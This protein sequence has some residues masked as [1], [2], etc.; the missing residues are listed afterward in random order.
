MNNRKQLTINLGEDHDDWVQ[1]SRDL[2]KRPATLARNVLRELIKDYKDAKTEKK[3]LKVSSCIREE[4]KSLH[5]RLNNAELAMLESYAAQYGYS[6]PR[7]AIAILRS[8]LKKEVQF[9]IAERE[10][11]RESNSLIRSIGVNLNQIA[12]SI[13]K[14]NPDRL[15]DSEQVKMLIS[16]IVQRADTLY[17]NTLTHTKYVYKLINSAKNRK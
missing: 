6:K 12:K 16:K 11:L 17:T 13:N 7:A 4:Q 10:A 14:I 5:L 3:I 15:N 9:T 8:F 2:K 1:I